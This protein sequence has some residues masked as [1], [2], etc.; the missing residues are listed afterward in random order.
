MFIH[1]Y[2]FTKYLNSMHKYF[3]ET[4]NTH[5][6]VLELTHSWVLYSHL[7]DTLLETNAL[8]SSCRRT[9][10]DYSH[11]GSSATDVW[12]YK[13]FNELFDFYRFKLFN[14]F[15]E[16]L[17]DTCSTVTTYLMCHFVD[18]HYFSHLCL[19]QHMWDLTIWPCRVIVAYVLYFVH[20][21][22]K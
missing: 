17:F 9:F 11:L 5:W 8:G 1:W 13:Y 4:Q 10:P 14:E 2:K 15:S 21:C 12:F 20:M 19:K 16:F 6:R 7:A 18:S 22:M 3:T